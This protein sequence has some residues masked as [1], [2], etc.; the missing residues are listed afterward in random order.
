MSAAEV[1]S[2]SESL[3]TDNRPK[4]GEAL[5]RQLVEAKKLTP[6][7]AQAISQ[8][9]AKALVF[10]EYVVLDKIGQGGMGVVLKAQHRR[11]KRLV[12]VKMICR[13]RP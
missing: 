12:A 3:P 2:F 6:Y 9:N 7:Q 11:M 13:G 4:D 5:A 1:S 8:G 10:D